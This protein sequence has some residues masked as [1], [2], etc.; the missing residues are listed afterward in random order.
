LVL[1]ILNVHF[2]LAAELLARGANPNAEA[3]G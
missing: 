2:Q 3:Q 1:A